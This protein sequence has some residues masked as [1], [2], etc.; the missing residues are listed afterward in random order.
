MKSAFIKLWE[1]IRGGYFEMGSLVVLNIY[2]LLFSLTI[3]LLPAATLA[4]YFAVR[5]MQAAERDYS[6]KLFFKG[7]KMYVVK[8]WRWFLPNMLLISLFITNILLFWVENNTITILVKAGN[9]A[10]LLLWL[11]FQTFL[12]PL[13]MEQEQQT[14]RLALSNAL[15]VFFKQPGLYGIT[16]LFVW[17]LLIIS[18]ILMMPW[19]VITISFSAYVQTAVLRATLAEVK[20]QLVPPHNG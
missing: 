12:L 16:T 6:H 18:L 3:I 2:W 13:M 4:L 20:Q 15:A 11:W 5:E 9:L 17:L 7:L 14:M 8:G 10:M 19:V 1:A